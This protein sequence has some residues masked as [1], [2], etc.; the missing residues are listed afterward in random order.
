M[1]GPIVISKFQAVFLLAY[2]YV[3][4]LYLFY[5]AQKAH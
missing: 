4:M 3:I 1:N 5:L 2:I